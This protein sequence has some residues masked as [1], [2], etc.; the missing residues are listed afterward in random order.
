MRGKFV[1]YIICN[2][3]A[4]QKRHLS[5]SQHKLHTCKDVTIQVTSAHVQWTEQYSHLL[6]D[7]PGSVYRPVLVEAGSAAVPAYSH[8]PYREYSIQ[9]TII[10]VPSYDLGPPAPFPVQNCSPPL[11]LLP[12]CIRIA[13]LRLR[14]RGRVAP[15]LTTALWYSTEIQYSLLRF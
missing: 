1:L 4:L 3:K 8:I 5:S 11:S 12:A 10:S 14:G 7:A 15:N 6:L 2:S 13:R 9:S